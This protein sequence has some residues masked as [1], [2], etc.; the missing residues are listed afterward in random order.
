MPSITKYQWMLKEVDDPSVVPQIAEALNDLP[1]ALARALVLRGVTTFEAARDYF[2]PSRE[3]LH[4]PFLMQ[5]MDAA[6][7]R[8]A[9]A[10]QQ[11][12]RVLVYGDY[13]VD[14]TTSS[15]L[16]TDFL[17]ARGVEADY[18]IPD[19]FEHGYGLNKAGIDHAAEWGARLIIAIDCGITAVEE[20]AYA[21]EQGIDLIICDH[22]TAPKAMP[23]AVA[24]LD[25]KRPECGYPFKELSGCGVAFK[26]VQATLAR[27]GDDPEHAFRYL[28]LV[29]ISTASD[30]VPLHGENRV[31][32]REAF[33]R[34]AQEP[35]RLGLRALAEQ[36]G[37]DFDD[38]TVD[39]IVFTIGPRINA[40][41]RMQH[42]SQAV[43]LLLADDMDEARHLARELDRV[44][45]DRRELDRAIR[46]E[47]FR[48]ADLQMA[49]RHRHALVLHDADWHQGVIGIVASRLVEQFHRP[50]I[51]LCTAN[52]AAKGSAR[53]VNAVNIYEALTACEDLLT[54]FGGHDYAAGMTLPEENVPALR[55]RL[56]AVVGE[57]VDGK[58]NA[59][60]PTIEVDAHV[61][62]SDIDER[63]WAVLKQFAPF[64]P[65]NMKPIFVA[66]DLQVVG[67]PRTVGKSDAHLKFRVGHDGAPTRDAI[68]FGL[69]GHLATLQRSQRQ[70]VPFKLAFSLE[71]NTWRGR[72]TLQL[73][74][75]DLQLQED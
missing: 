72:T 67:R 60:M 13:D 6:A 26:L 2:R 21:R 34:M 53:S 45:K 51:M 41:G 19:R 30:I 57:M 18:F 68:G 75:R 11:G 24:V 65:E 39:R 31:L 16:M 32:M 52:G 40:A 27:L 4:D 64:G 71:E 63:F 12:E 36:S 49:G 9:Q 42:A 74:A 7:D 15:A 10:I 48:K 1:E 50:S 37:I 35:P 69:G 3:H 58:P 44:N 61:A 23:E 29:A 70:G 20:A 73:R 38:V 66:R 33:A 47:A 46:D 62:L 25:P 54:Q 56:D 43:D 5:D 28:D 22:H 17:R 55:D 8:V 59:F 14:G